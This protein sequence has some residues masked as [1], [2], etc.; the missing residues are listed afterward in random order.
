MKIASEAPSALDRRLRIALFLGWAAL[1]LFLASRHVFWRDEVRAFSIAL[2]GSGFREMLEGLHGEGHPALWYLI[3]RAGHEIV[4]VREVLPVAAGLIAAAAMALLVFRSPFRAGIVAL[5]LFGAAGLFEYSV[6]ARNYGISMLILFAI[7]HFYPERRDRGFLLGVLLALLCNTNVHSVFLAAAFLLFWLVELVSE[8]GLKWTPR[9]RTFA[10]NAAL[11]AVGALLCFLTVYPASH[12]AAVLAHPGGITPSAIAA[13]IFA[14]PESLSHLAPQALTGH[15]RFGAFLLTIV[16]LGSLGGLL[17]APGAL[18]ST[19]AVLLLF[20]LLFQLVYPGG[21]RHQSLFVIYLVT[22]YWLVARGR[23]GRWPESWRGLESPRLRAAGAG[24]FT[25]LL[26]FQLPASAALLAAEARNIP[27]SRARD[28]AELLRREKLLDATLLAE[29]DVVLE[30]MPY[31][32][33]NPIYLLRDQ[34]YGNVVRF[35]RNAR[36]ELDLGQLLEDARAIQERTGKPVVIVVQHRLDP[37]E[38]L[39]LREV[40]VWTFRASSEQVRRFLLATRRIGSFAPARSDESY[41]VY[42]LESR[43][44][45]G[46][47]RS[48]SST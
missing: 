10:A 28:L 16:L 41:D 48:A 3:L 13:A 17:A 21:Y 8:D 20:T 32:V 4:P 46:R 6:M 37:N 1:V 26:A 19:L 18:L 5:L 25:L 14:L 7:A 15:G 35:T 36:T 39:S 34:R 47:L 38:S 43:E 33:P 27:A 42:L 9:Y 44:M 45:S 24:F 40:Y 22:M 31:Y 23:G 12:D 11:A 30:P 29:P 2:N